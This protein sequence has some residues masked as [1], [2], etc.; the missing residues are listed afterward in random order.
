MKIVF[1]V[2]LAFFVLDIEERENI[3]F[4]L[5]FERIE[6]F[7]DIDRLRSLFKGLHSQVRSCHSSDGLTM[8]DV[9][10]P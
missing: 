6:K 2:E 4:V 3:L 10:S 1:F 8:K 9:R 7:E 5:H